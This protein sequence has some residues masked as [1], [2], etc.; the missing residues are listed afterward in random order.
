M[1]NAL[2]RIASLRSKFHF[3]LAISDVAALSKENFHQGLKHM[4]ALASNLDECVLIAFN[5]QLND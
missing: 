4:R 3:A 1:G 2:K 5:A